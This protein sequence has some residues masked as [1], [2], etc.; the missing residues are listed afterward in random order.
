MRLAKK[1]FIIAVI[2]LALLAVFCW[3]QN[4]YIT[5]SEYTYETE[6]ISAEN[7]GFIIVQIS[8]LHNKSFGQNQNNKTI[9]NSGW[10]LPS[11][12]FF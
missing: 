2:L 3:F 9:K 4:N 6:E 1:K 5:V 12:E 7:D 11:A 8:D 10:R